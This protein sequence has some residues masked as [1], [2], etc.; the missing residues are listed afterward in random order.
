MVLLT[1]IPPESS[2]SSSS[3][4]HDYDVFL[5]FRGADIRNSFTDH[6]YNALLE[7]DIKTFLDDEEIETGEPLKP[8]LESAIKSSRASIIVLSKNYASSTWCL[9]ELVLILHQNQNCNQIV[10][11]IFYDVEPT[12]IRKQQSSFGEAMGKHK[13][14]ME[15]E[16]DAEKRSE[17][18]KKMDS[19]KRALTEVA[20]LKGKDAKDRKETE[21]I[22]E[23]VADIHRRL[24]VL[25]S[26]T[27]P[28]LIG[29]DYKIR[30]ISSWLTNGSCK[31]ADI[32]TIVGMSGI[33][34]TS[35]ARY[36]F[37]LHSSKFDKSS[38]IEGINA[39]CSERFNGLLDL[40]KQ[41][42]GDILKNI[43]LQVHDVSV[44]TSKIENAL[45]RKR[46]F[47]VL[48]DIGSL[49]QLNA[50][51]GSKGKGLHPGSKVIITTKDASLT[52]RCALFDTPVQ[53]NH[54]MVSL[55]GLYEFKSLELLCIHA[56]KSNKPKEGYKEVSEK[57]VKYCEGH[58]LALQV[59][60]TSLH[61]RDVAYWEDCIKVLKKELL[62]YIN[63]AL[64]LSFDALP[65]ENDK[66]LFKHI[67]CFFV[68]IDR[69]VVETILD[70]CDINTRYGITNLIDKCLLGI[71]RNNK[72]I[73][74]QLVQEMGRDLVCEESRDK[75]WKRSRLWCHEESLKVLEQKKGTENL[76]GLALDMRMLEKENLSGS[77]QLETDAFSKMEVD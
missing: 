31:T 10:I 33:G 8:E 28:R 56:F 26:N 44:Y 73:M 77:L 3:S 54:K 9:D 17:L 55:N 34:K 71:T 72:L 6:L 41:L 25:L 19:W 58:P 48:D 24:G 66:E 1:E 7:A 36:V 60:G 16:T 61:K 76:I 74:H 63:T 70:A 12:D 42:C 21:F 11:P 43:P 37:G 64:K 15:E 46:V 4:T 5:S 49:D 30:S 45:A 2:S 75:P 59:L 40:Q 35:L 27:L 39:R 22:K 50:L 18:A 47:I 14:K 65:S 29:M 13:Q 32:L 53:P 57:L 23:V 69:D 20:D 38:F 68:G 51:L 67:A 52:E 62:S